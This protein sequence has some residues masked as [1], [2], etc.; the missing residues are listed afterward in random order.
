[1]D[2]DP[3]D[4]SL[5]QGRDALTRGE[6]GQALKSFELGCKICERRG[7]KPDENPEL[8]KLHAGITLLQSCEQAVTTS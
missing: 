8:Q 6:I 4:E 1:M 2:L 5:K 7:A 3:L